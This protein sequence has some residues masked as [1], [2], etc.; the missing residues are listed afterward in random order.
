M[1]RYYFHL[2]HGSNLSRRAVDEEGDELSGPEAVRP[3]ALK[4]ARDLIDRTRTDIVR[5]WFTCAFEVTDEA[6]RSVMTVPFAEIVEP[7]E[8]GHFMPD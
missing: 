2:R 7:D 8:G 5:D 1:P 4:V 6:G 3:H